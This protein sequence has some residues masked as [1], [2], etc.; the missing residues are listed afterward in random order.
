MRSGQR[1]EGRGQRREMTIV[2]GLYSIASL[3][4]A[5]AAYRRDTITLGWEERMR[6]HG[7]RVSD[8]GIEFGTSLPRATVL[9]GGDLFVL[10]EEQVVCEVVERSEPVFLIEPRSTQEWAAFAYQI[11]N[12]HQPVMITDT[13]LVCPDV[14]GV[15]PLLQQHAMP[16]ERATRPFTPLANVIGHSH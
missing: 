10:D 7:R 2:E 8:G 15:E 6:A 11:G 13:A 16:Y 1:A 5:A 3:P 14:P 9:H 4:I 12:R